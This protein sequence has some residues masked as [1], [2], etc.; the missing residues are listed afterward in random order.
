MARRSSLCFLVSIGTFALCVPTAS[1]AAG[2]PDLVPSEVKVS[3]A[4]ITSGQTIRVSWTMANKGDGDAKASVTGLR[5]KAVW[6][7]SLKTSCAGPYITLVR[8]I[9]TDMITAGGWI[10]AQYD[11]AVPADAPAGGYVVEVVAD[12]SNPS[13]LGQKD[14]GN[15][16]A[17]SGEVTVSSQSAS[18]TGRPLMADM[19]LVPEG[20]FADPR[21]PLPLDEKSREHAG[22]DYRAAGGSCVFAVREGEVES[23]SNRTLN[24]RPDG[25]RTDHQAR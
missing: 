16:Y 20:A 1:I 7:G 13:T 14:T 21:Y 4:S 25:S 24:S 3:T 22:T 2:S 19:E 18:S 10:S 8:E 11:V 9:A 6:G 23:E 5:L 15:D 12:N 17:Q